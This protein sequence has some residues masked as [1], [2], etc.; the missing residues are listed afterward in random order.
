MP[1]G[2]DLWQWLYTDDFGKQRIFPCGL[3]EETAK[4]LRSAERFE[5]TLEIRKPTESTND[6]LRSPRPPS[7]FAASG[8]PGGCFGTGSSSV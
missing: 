4:P 6:W 5:S 2:I 3:S 7:R 1:H 8:P